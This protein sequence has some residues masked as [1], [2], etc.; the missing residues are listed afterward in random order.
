MVFL[1]QAAYSDIMAGGAGA[2]QGGTPLSAT[3]GAIRP[4]RGMAWAGGGVVPEHATGGALHG[5]V[6][7]SSGDVSRSRR[8]VLV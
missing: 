3:G 1:A 6:P 8:C 4:R 7:R 5:L 2:G